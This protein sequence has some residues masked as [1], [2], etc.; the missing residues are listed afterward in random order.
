[1]ILPLTGLKPSLFR[2]S[3]EALLKISVVTAV[4]NRQQTIADAIDSVASQT[5]NNLEYVVID[6]M[7]TDGT[8]EVINSNSKPIHQSIREPDTGI[9]DALNKGIA[10]STGDVIGF[11]HADDL[12]ADAEVVQR[13]Q[14]TFQSGD[15]DAVYA[16]LTYVAFDDPN[17]IIRYWRSGKYS[18]KRFRLGWM[19]PHPTVYVKRDIYEKYGSY[20][21][22]LGTAADYECMIRLMVK[23]QIRVGYIP[24]IAVKMRVGGESNASMKNR[25]KANVADLAAWTENGLKPPFG[26]RFTKP[27]FKLPQYWR[28]PRL[29]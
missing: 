22:D 17:R 28:R 12:F 18:M 5:C 15:Y 16:D 23:N 6:G 14:D 3:K 8:A 11:L 19:P 26:L 24:E 9:Y 27:L 1:M 4:Y 25:L 29:K 21:T 7:S 2:P 20:R 13:V 10:V